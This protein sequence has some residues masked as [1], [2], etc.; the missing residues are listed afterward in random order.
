[1]SLNNNS[2]TVYVTG[3]PNSITEDGVVEYVNTLLAKSNQQIESDQLELVCNEEIK[4]G[5]CYIDMSSNEQCVKLVGL[6]NRTPFDT[7]V[8]AERSRKGRKKI[9]LKA[10]LYDMND[11]Q[12]RR[13]GSK[14][15]TEEEV[16]QLG[17]EIYDYIDIH[18]P[19]FDGMY[20]K[21][22]KAYKHIRI[23]LLSIS[24][25]CS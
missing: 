4:V 19:N 12:H 24:G 8:Y 5:Y 11:G 15:P 3:F 1:M 22:L 17:D 25:H 10:K 7:S 13:R 20:T 23:Y 16:N 14:K 18:I 2:T 6:I 21:R 9:A